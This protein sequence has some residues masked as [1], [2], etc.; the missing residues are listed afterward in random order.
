M[1]ANKIRSNLLLEIDKEIINKSKVNHSLINGLSIKEFKSK[2]N[3]IIEFEN[4]FYYYCHKDYTHR[5]KPKIFNDIKRES[6]IKQNLIIKIKPNEERPQ[7]AS[8]ININNRYSLASKK[9]IHFNSSH[10]IENN[11]NIPK[12]SSIKGKSKLISKLPTFKVNLVILTNEEKDLLNFQLHYNLLNQ[13]SYYLKNTKEGCYPTMKKI[14]AH[15]LLEVKSMLNK[16]IKDLVNS[17]KTDIDLK[18]ISIAKLQE[19]IITILKYKGLKFDNIEFKVDDNSYPRRS[20]SISFSS[21]NLKDNDLTIENKK[22]LDDDCYLS[23]LRSQTLFFNKQNQV[24]DVNDCSFSIISEE[25]NNNVIINEI[26][27]EFNYSSSH[28]SD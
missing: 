5:V 7:K 4:P 12:Q 19:D 3:I 11:I 8:I 18:F 15:N 22:S 25:H 6:K 14:N 17:N 23:R 21:S 1:Q 26:D 24:I 10:N 27:S 28:C 20:N 13:I 16:Y 9:L 2:H